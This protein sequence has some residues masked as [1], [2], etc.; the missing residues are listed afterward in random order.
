MR[1]STDNGVKVCLLYREFHPYSMKSAGLDLFQDVS[2]HLA[3]DLFSKQDWRYNGSFAP[4]KSGWIYILADQNGAYESCLELKRKIFLKY[5]NPY[6]F[7]IRYRH[8]SFGLVLSAR[9]NCLKQ[10]LFLNFCKN[11]IPAS[12][13]E[14]ALT[15]YPKCGVEKVIKV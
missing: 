10:L 7:D 8:V 6:K 4:M 14:E 5:F 15:L 2:D 3:M 12:I 13:T 11:H 9:V 1:S